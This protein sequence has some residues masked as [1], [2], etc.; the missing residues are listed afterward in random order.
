MSS[1]RTAGGAA[2]AA[3][4]LALLFTTPA[5]A[6]DIDIKSAIDAVTV[7]PDGATVTRRATAGLPA[8]A[9]TIVFKGLPAALDPASLRVTGQGSAQ[10]AIGSVEV[11]EV[12]GDTKSAA[13]PELEAKI[14]ALT[15]DKESVEGKLQAAEGKREMI[16]RYA[17]ASPEKL[18]PEAKPLDV[19]QW[20]GAWDAVGTALAQANNEI[21]VLTQRV[22]DI[23]KE[24]ETLEEAQPDEPDVGQPKRNVLV[25]VDA[26]LPV[27]AALSLS[28]RVGGA[29]WRPLYDA[30]LDTGAGGAGGK[31][32]KP[33]LELIRRAEVTQTTGEDWSNVALSVS[34]VSVARGTSA[35]ELPPSQ[36]A[37]FEP[38]PP[39]PRFNS[40]PSAALSAPKS[41]ALLDKVAEADAK[42]PVKQAAAEEQEASLESAGFQASFNVPGRVVVQQDGSP[43]A[44]RLASRNVAP[45]LSVKSAPVV[46]EAAYLEASFV[47]EDEAA[48]LPGEVAIHRDDTFVGRGRIGLVA[49]GDKV[50]L[51]F[52]SD[53]RV[54]VTRVP[55]KR[56]QEE[57]GVFSSSK[58]DQ[59]EFKTTVKNLHN[60]PVKVTIIDRVPFSENA[61]IAVEMLSQTTVPTEKVVKDRRGVMAW[62]YDYAAGEQ[63]E[64]RLAYRLKWPAEK[65][66]AI[67]G[68][69]QR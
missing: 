20:A 7:Y 12:P 17:A 60:F 28:Y 65:A 25:S 10:F 22:K 50:E 44:F 6:A 27:E 19:A 59:R 14:K 29:R 15:A 23:A 56:A 63:K 8:G 40:A 39:T 58:T 66:I 24:I 49:P 67:D 36:V 34:T 37:F 41:R 35:P 62:S 18:G 61:A 21:R 64:I 33:S 38:R 54:K 16:K 46:D 69:P 42:E 1:I 43:R 52:G 11:K 9:S 13:N 45:S 3:T 53:E 55:V 48:L 26:N 47:N 4:A 5:F 57:P 68:W 2:A 30:R 51:G 31:G 32:G